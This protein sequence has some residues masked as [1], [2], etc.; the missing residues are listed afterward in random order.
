M[1]CVYIFFANFNI[2][3]KNNIKTAIDTTK[4]TPRLQFLY[5]P[6]ND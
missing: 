4:N 6:F 5:R 3:N 2:Y 1:L